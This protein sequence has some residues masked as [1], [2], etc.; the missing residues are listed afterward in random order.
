MQATELPCSVAMIPPSFSQVTIS[1]VR[2]E[3]CHPNYPLWLF[4]VPRGKTLG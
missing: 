3:V 4:L 1:I 2:P